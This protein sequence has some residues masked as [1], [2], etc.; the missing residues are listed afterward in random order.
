MTM[1]GEGANEKSADRKWAGVRLREREREKMIVKKKEKNG[2]KMESS[3]GPNIG[4][5]H[6]SRKSERKMDAIRS[7]AFLLSFF[8][9][10]FVVRFRSFPIEMCCRCRSFLHFPPPVFVAR[11]FLLFH[12]RID[13]GFYYNNREP[14]WLPHG[15]QSEGRT[16]QSRVERGPLIDRFE[17]TNQMVAF[18]FQDGGER[19]VESGA[20]KGRVL[21]IESVQVVLKFHW[22]LCVRPFFID[23]NVVSKKK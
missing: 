9:F 17:A 14:D 1:C 3:A 12:S 11:S 15:N 7:T 2:N 19:K 8:F 4:G 16:V 20:H 23:M 22:F 6:Y 10:W 5:R 18:P 21:G 13:T